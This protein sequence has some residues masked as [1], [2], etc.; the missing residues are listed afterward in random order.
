LQI[1]LAKL[2]GREAPREAE[3]GRVFLNHLIVPFGSFGSDH[4]NKCFFFCMVLEIGVAAIP[5]IIRMGYGI[6]EGHRV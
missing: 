1:F 3:K 2:E 4:V 5:A 6:T